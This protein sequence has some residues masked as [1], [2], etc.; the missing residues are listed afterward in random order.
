VTPVELSLL[1]AAI[2]IAGGTDSLVILLVVL[3]FLVA[4]MRRPR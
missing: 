3:T 1:F 4:A 2:A